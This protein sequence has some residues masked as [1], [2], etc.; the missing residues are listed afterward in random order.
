MVDPLSLSVLG[1][2]AL[3]EGIKFLYGQTTEL[4]KR[5]RDREQ[6]GE[7][8]AVPCTEVVVQ[9]S[10]LLDQPLSR[11][12]VDYDIVATHDQQLRDLRGGLADYVDG[13]ADVDPTDVRLLK[14]VA[15]LRALLELAY[16]QHLTFQGEQR[17]ATGTPLSTEGASQA[18]T[19]AAQVTASGS[20]AVAVGRDNVGGIHTSTTQGTAY[21]LDG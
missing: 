11:V 7:D 6:A 8:G 2:V 17:P 13:L 20:G 14:Q 3:T 1:G 18:S 15:S 5:R 10:E 21:R 19:Y 16:G 12:A 4:L 9:R